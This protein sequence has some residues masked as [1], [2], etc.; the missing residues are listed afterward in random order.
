MGLA[1]DRRAEAVA[2]GQ[3]ALLLALLDSDTGTGT[4]D[5]STADLSVPFGKGGKW[6][7]SIPSGL[8][9]KRIIKRVGVRMSDRPSRHRGFVSVWQIAD[10]DKAKQEIQLLTNL[11]EAIQKDPQP[12]ATGAGKANS[13]TTIP[14][15]TKEN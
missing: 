1:A 3:I 7:G 15:N 13:K 14:T 5:D 4:I 11:L 12:A 10:R 2:A 8:S 9:R 6:R